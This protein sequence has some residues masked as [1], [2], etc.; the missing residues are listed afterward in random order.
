MVVSPTVRR[1]TSRPTDRITYSNRDTT[2]DIRDEGLSAEANWKT[3]W[4]GNATLTSITAWRDWKRTGQTDPDYTSVDILYYDAAHQ[5]AEFEQFSQ[6]LRLAGKSGAVDWL[7]GGFYAN[8]KLTQ[9]TS[10]RYGTQF[11]TYASLLA[12]GGTNPTLVSTLEGRAPGTSFVAGQGQKDHYDQKESNFAAFTNDTWHVTDK[13][14]LTGGLRYTHE[15][16]TLDTLYTNTDGGLGCATLATRLGQSGTAIALSPLLCGSY[17]NYLFSN[18][19]DHQSLTEEKVTGTIKAAYRWSKEVLTYASYARGYKAGG[20]NLDRLACPYQVGTAASNACVASI[21]ASGHALQA[22]P[23][24]GAGAQNSLQPLYDTSFK[25]EFVDSYEIGIKNTLFDR[26]LLLNFTG[27]YQKF[28]N[29]QLNAYNGLVFTVTGV[30]EVISQGVDADFVF[31]PM[32]G[33]SISGGVTYADTRY[34]NTAANI[35]VL[36]QPF[37]SAACPTR[38]AY[39]GTIPAGCSFLPGSRLSLAPLVS[40]SLAITYETPVTNDLLARFNLS[41]K[42][43]SDYNTGSDLNP[44]K[45]Q[46]AFALLNGRVG[47]GPQ[48]RPLVFRGVVAEPAQ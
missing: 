26:R 12:S 19:P 32:R 16:K 24:A 9:D 45:L 46:K 37:G 1:R 31:L 7:V 25:P 47:I 35:A 14:E 48:K 43:S 23:Q 11:E 17:Q 20:F 39:G 3:G 34:S 18:L 41:S 2:Q 13:F 33:L 4:F 44:V 8:E 29:F 22:N 6:E 28:T 38:P 36:G 40:A 5:G 15:R 30:P 21:A 10:L 27:F 42:Y